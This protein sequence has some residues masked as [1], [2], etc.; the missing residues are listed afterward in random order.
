[1]VDNQFICKLCGKKTST[2]N[3]AISRHLKI[4]NIDFFKYISD[5]YKLVGPTTFESCAF[6]DK[7]A[8]PKYDIDHINQTYVIRYDHGYS[9]GDIECKKIIS[10]KM[11]GVEYDPKKFEKIGSR[12]DYLSMLYKIPI[13]D[14]KKMKFKGN[15]K[16][17]KNSIDEYILLYGEEDGRL[18]YN[19]RINKIRYKSEKYSKN[20]IKCNLSGF[21]GKYGKEIGLI[22]YNERCDKISKTNTIDYFKEKYG[23]VDGVKIFNKKH[24]SKKISDKSKIVKNILDSLNIDYIVEFKI[25]NRS[26]DYLLPEYKVIIEY[27][28]DYWHCNP[29]NYK[30]DYQHPQIKMFASEIWEKDIY[31]YNCIV[32]EGYSVLVVWESSNIDSI[33]LE[34]SINDI[35]GKKIIMNI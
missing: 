6:C 10:L 13:E 1:M 32:S 17:F 33:V 15:G 35:R 22:K 31:R 16:R 19:D 24:K 20:L 27:N 4:H 21:I 30:H 12:S 14:S 26:V 23:E 29:K 7:V 28:G 2:V 9:C 3:Y 5:Y 18:R 34:K 8:K 11:L 25:G